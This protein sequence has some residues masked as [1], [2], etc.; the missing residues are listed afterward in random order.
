MRALRPPERMTVSHWADRHRILDE[1]SSSAPG[2]WRTSFTPYLAG[3]MDAFTDPDIEEIWFCKCT[4]VGGTEAIL[5]MMGYAISQDPG[6]TLVVYPTLDLAE[7]ISTVRI[8]PMIDLCSALKTEYLIGQS[9]KLE[10]Q[11]LSAYLALSGANSPASL[12][13]RP[14]RYLFLDEVD[15]FPRVAAK[16]ADPINLSAERTKTFAYNRKIVGA[17]TPTF[18]HNH[19]WQQMEAANEVRRYFVPCPHCGHYQTFRMQQLKWPE[20]CDADEARDLAYY[21]CEACQGRITDAHKLTMLR[22]GEWRADEVRGHGKRVVAYHLNTFY[23]P[24]VRLGD[25]AHQFLASKDDP[26]ELQNF[27]NSWLAEAWEEAQR[28]MSAD[29][30]RERETGHQ[31]GEVPDG[32]VMI[33]GGVDV[34]QDSLYWTIRAWGPLL[35]SWNV[36]HGQALSWLEIEQVMNRPWQDRHG[37]EFVVALCAIDSG[38]GNTQEDVYDFCAENADWTV[39]VKGSSQPLLSRYR[40]STIDKQGKAFGLRLVIVDGSQ[41]KTMIASRMNRQNGRG[42]WMVYQG[43][44]RDYATQVTSE[45]CVREKRG[46][47]LVDV[48]MPKTS[49]AAN[50]YLDAEV[51][52]ACAAELMGAR[53]LTDVEDTP[54]PPA[55]LPEERGESGEREGWLR[56]PLGRWV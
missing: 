37:R 3:I 47:R 29:L 7:H 20:G 22:A 43:C 21:E 30:V 8:Q 24:W 17:S 16:E 38:D 39:A 23:S 6:P 11:F 4:Q 54:S 19:I 10:L 18:K 45:H 36:A 25:I 35:T 26:V 48:W 31:E 14:I 52:C 42:S 49:G 41:Y 28:R 1:K 33:T 13:S 5:N 46:A 55:P 50:H 40:L 27:V 12:A 15:K 56:Q 9:K 53:H 51:Y 34:Q 2:P 44:D 32:A